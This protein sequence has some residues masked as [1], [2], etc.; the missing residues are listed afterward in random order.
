MNPFFFSFCHSYLDL[1]HDFHAQLCFHSHFVFTAQPLLAVYMSDRQ[2]S[3]SRG[4]QVAATDPIW[5]PC[6]C[7]VREENDMNG[8]L[9]SH[10]ETGWS[11]SDFDKC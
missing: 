6:Y 10:E 8:A 1:S 9:E 11:F 3:R 4:R 2:A 7:A 5:D